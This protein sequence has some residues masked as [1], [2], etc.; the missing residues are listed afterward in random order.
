[1]IFIA[2][3]NN[4]SKK[5][6]I[7]CIIFFILGFTIA[8]IRQN[9]SRYHDH[10]PLNK[11][12]FLKADVDHLLTYPN[13]RIYTILK[14]VV[15][16]Y[17]GKKYKINS[18]VL[19][20]IYDRSCTV[21]PGQQI[22]G[23]FRLKKIR[24]YL[25]PGVFDYKGLYELKNIH[26][27]MYTNKWKNNIITVQGNANFLWKIK[28]YVKKRLLNEMKNIQNKGI[29]LSLIT[30]DRSY[31]TTNH[32]E[33]LRKGSLSHLIAQS[34]LHVGF[35]ALL[36]FII[37]YIIG[38]IYP[39]IFLKIPR[40]KLGCII[41]GV[42]VICFFVISETRPSIIRASVMFFC[43]AILFLK[44]HKYAIIDGLF[45]SF[46][47]L[48]LMDTF[49]IFDIGLQLSYMSVLAIILI[50]PK[51]D[52]KIPGYIRSNKILYYTISILLISFIINMILYPIISYYFG[53][54]SMAFYTNVV[55]IP[56][57]GFIIL[58]CMIFATICSI[59]N[60][61]TGISKFLILICDK[62][63][64]LCIN[65]LQ[66][67]NNIHLLTTLPSIRPNSFM[68]IGYYLLFMTLFLRF[69]KNIYKYILLIISFL[70][71]SIPISMKYIDHFKD[72]LVIKVLDVG[73]GQSILI[74]YM[75]NRVLIDGGGTWNKNFD[76][77]RVV[78]SPVL[79]YL[80]LPTIDKLILTH[81]DTDHIGGLFYLIKKYKIGDFYYN[82]LFKT[83]KALNYFLKIARYRKIPIHVVKKGNI[84]KIQKNLWI[85]VMNP[86]D[87][88]YRNTNN[89]A[90]ILK[91]I[92]HN[93]PVLFITSDVDSSILRYLSKFNIRSNILIVPHHGSKNSFSRIFLT[94]VNPKIAIISSGYLNRFGFPDK[95]WMRYFH[96]HNIKTYN[97]ATDGCINISY[98][99]N[100]GKIYHNITTINHK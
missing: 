2:S 32:M 85:K 95:K 14:H 38:Y 16:K 77:G 43:W 4:I 48:I 51:L 13:H 45:I 76:F 9:K 26:I 57:I 39:E 67:L 93:K 92:Y 20:K 96:I 73:Q 41:A 22:K 44:N 70:M 91:L 89:S 23:I 7:F 75:G 11:K 84:I 12:I 49:S 81:P 29:L 65:L 74:E 90:L 55:F 47:L 58:P 40:Q 54:I 19:W 35:V 36:G 56:I 52:K 61:T 50:F 31:V 24:G 64:S 15:C 72:K 94:K 69:K 88:Y 83:K 30:G 99:L 18:Y 1:M 46:L 71:I 27:V 21:L 98:V 82:G 10:V 87:N 6:L 34:G 66:Y 33:L 79:T 80:N 68:I 25:N 28:D 5:T 42:L 8:K 37:A 53:E 60:L 63:I 3:I 86:I 62:I 78:L 59:F 97:T 100:N 17:K